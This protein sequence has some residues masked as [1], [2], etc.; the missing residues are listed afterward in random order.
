MAKITER[1]RGVA[2]SLADG[3]ST[4]VYLL[5]CEGGLILIDVGFTEGFA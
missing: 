2:V 3:L 1:I 5:D 4:M